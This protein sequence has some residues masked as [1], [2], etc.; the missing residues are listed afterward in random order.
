VSGEVLAFFNTVEPKQSDAF[1]FS[2]EGRR[3]RQRF[4]VARSRDGGRTWSPA[5]PFSIGGVPRDTYIGIP[6]VVFPDGRL[7]LPV[8]ATGANR[9]ELILAA[10]S[11]DGG[12]TFDPATTWVHDPTGTVSYG[13]AR[14]TML[15]DGRIVFLVWAFATKTEETLPVHRCVSSDGG[16]TWSA[17]RGV[18][19]MSQIMAPLALDDER[20]ML[21][22][23]NVR[24]MPEGIRLWY[25]TD[26]GESWDGAPPVMMWDARAE[27]IT[28]EPLRD[29]TGKADEGRIWDA[30]P[31]FSFGTPQLQP[32]GPA[33]KFALTY[34]ATVAG[35]LHVRCCRFRARLP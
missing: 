32:T 16:R 31:S 21:A 26:A 17:P 27:R 7:L 2:D 8:E 11:T 18:G 10:E 19:V 12:R 6:P 13:D 14:P 33:D 15:P 34:Y 25:S 29:A 9:E 3:L 24:T 22:V 1:V 20:R 4:N 28:G 35:I 5:E 23:S 30:L